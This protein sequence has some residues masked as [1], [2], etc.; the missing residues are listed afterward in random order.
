[1]SS[2]YLPGLL[3][4]L[5]VTMLSVVVLVMISRWIKNLYFPKEPEDEGSE[6]MMEFLVLNAQLEQ[7]A[8]EAEGPDD[9]GGTASGPK[10]DGGSRRSGPLA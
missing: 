4:G 8:A 5:V 3:L 10:S 1:M 2:S 6:A 7:R 9:G